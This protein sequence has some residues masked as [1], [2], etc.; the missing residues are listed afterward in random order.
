MIFEMENEEEVNAKKEI[1]IYF[2]NNGIPLNK[3]QVD[4][5]YNYYLLLIEWNK[6]FNLT[7]I[8]DFKEVIIKHFF[9][10]AVCYKELKPNAKVI[11]IGCGAG[12]PSIPLKIMREDLSFTL[13]DSVNKKITFINSLISK[14]GLTNV[15]A[16]HS[17]AEDLAFN[18]NFRQK[19]SYAVS[20]AVANLSTLCEYCLPFVSVGGSLLAYKSMGA[21]DEVKEAN[22]AITQLGGELKSIKDFTVEDYCRKLVIINKVSLTPNKYPRSN[23]KPRT[24]PL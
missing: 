6:K 3:R 1:S 4:L 7:A 14:L 10:S 18:A 23:N 22:I 2:E 9:D 16:I 20:R 17:R 19:Y 8:T 21:E 13:V 15:V 24:A 5:F 12:F 11:D